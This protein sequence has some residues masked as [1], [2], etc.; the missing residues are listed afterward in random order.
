MKTY[1]TDRSLANPMAQNNKIHDPVA[2][3]QEEESL[4]V[5][6]QAKPKNRMSLARDFSLKF[7]YQCESEKLYYFSAN[8]F[9]SFA[10]HFGIGPSTAVLAKKICLGTLSQIHKIDQIINEASSGWKLE[11]MALTDRTVLR[12]AT[13]ELLESKAPV[14]V[15]LNEAIELA[16]L[17]G[18]ENSGRFVNG[19]L[20]FLARKL[21]T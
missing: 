14:R 18:S 1:P 21:R 2:P 5:L 3:T 17:Y 4:P 20:D 15:V 6:P 10:S 8:H 13:Y 7:L 9:Q 12:M 16:K 19:I 11:R